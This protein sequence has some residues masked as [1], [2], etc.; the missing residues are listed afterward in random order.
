MPMTGLALKTTRCANNAYHLG[1][2]VLTRRLL[3]IW[4]D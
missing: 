1:Q 2:F 3:T 4:S